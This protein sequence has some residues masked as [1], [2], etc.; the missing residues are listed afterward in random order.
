MS[1]VLR[2][3]Y[4]TVRQGKFLSDAFPKE[5]NMYRGDALS[6]VFISLRTEYVH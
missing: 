1:G 6:H 2:E 3:A 5:N 4:S